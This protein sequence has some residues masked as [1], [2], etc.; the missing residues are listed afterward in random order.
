MNI[1]TERV[2]DEYDEQMFT[3]LKHT[4]RTDDNSPYVIISSSAK[5]LKLNSFLNIFRRKI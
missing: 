4:L 5:F 3:S 2:R 1:I